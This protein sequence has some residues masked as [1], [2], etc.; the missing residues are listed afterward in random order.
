MVGL[1]TL[2]NALAGGV[3]AKKRLAPWRC[4]SQRYG[5]RLEWGQ[6]AIGIMGILGIIGLGIIGIL[7]PIGIIHCCL[8]LTY[9]P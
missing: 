1:L 2:I 5:A 9:S 4:Y 7:G 3:G 6:W 8:L